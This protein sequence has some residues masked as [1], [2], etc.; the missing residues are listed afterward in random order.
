MTWSLRYAAVF[1][2]LVASMSVDGRLA[3][4]TEEAPSEKV[5]PDEGFGVVNRDDH[6]GTIDRTESNEEE[7]DPPADPVKP[8]TDVSA[9]P[10]AEGASDNPAVPPPPPPCVDW[11]PGSYD[12]AT[13]ISYSSVCIAWRVC[14]D[15]RVDDIVSGDIADG[16]RGHYAAFIDQTIG[17]LDAGAF[18]TVAGLDNVSSVNQLLNENGLTDPERRDDIPVFHG[19]GSSV[20]PPVIDTYDFTSINFTWT[21]GAPEVYPINGIRND[22][23]NKLK[24]R[25]ALYNPELGSV[26]DVG[27]TLVKWPTWLFLRNLLP[28]ESVYTTNDTDTF[29]VDLRAVLLQLDWYHGDQLLTSCTPNETTVWDPDWHDP[30]DDLPDCHHRFERRGTQD[31]NVQIVYKIEEDVRTAASSGAYP[32]LAWTDFLGTE[33][34]LA[35]EGTIPNYRVCEVYVVNTTSDIT[36]QDLRDR[37]GDAPCTQP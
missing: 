30:I 16:S 5:A 32:E 15:E 13:G 35:L 24:A 28:E 7:T 37:Y 1:L 9:G 31:L 18:T 21:L 23:Y 26:P 20:A 34:L 33:T 11:S 8:A 2:T 14:V 6:G 27:T 22:L 29:R 25:M 12:A 10:N 36:Q 19:C 3:H 4:A 17:F